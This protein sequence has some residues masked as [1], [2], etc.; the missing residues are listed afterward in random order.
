MNILNAEDTL[1][2][3]EGTATAVIDGRVV[4]LFEVKNVNAKVSLD[5]ADIKTLGNR[6]VQ[7]KVKG[8]TGEGTLNMYLTTSRWTKMVINYIKTGKIQK[9]D[10]NLTNDDPQSSIGRQIIKVSGCL[11]DGADI[12]KLDV[13]SDALE[14]EV[15]FTFENADILEEFK[16]I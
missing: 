10:M 8:W 1:N 4:D 7:K 3:A 6:G 15:N 16:E 5:K 9:F 12:A 11:I 14:Q 13:D 2:G